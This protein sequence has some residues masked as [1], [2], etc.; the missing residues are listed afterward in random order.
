MSGQLASSE[1]NW[2][3]VYV[4]FNIPE[5][6]IVAGRLQS[7]GIPAFI[8]HALGASAIGITIGSLGEVKVLVRAQD[9]ALAESLLYPD[10]PDEL[11]DSTDDVRYEWDAEDDDDE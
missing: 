5:A 6:H 7:E 10:L 11:P 1:S 9:A 2:Y 4:C 3:V 8:H